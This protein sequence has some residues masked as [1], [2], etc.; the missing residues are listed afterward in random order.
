MGTYASS[1]NRKYTRHRLAVTDGT[2]HGPCVLCN[3]DLVKFGLV[4]LEICERTDRQTDT[5]IAIPHIHAGGVKLIG[6]FI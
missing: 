2:I 6:A 3:E 5:L 4:V 1:A